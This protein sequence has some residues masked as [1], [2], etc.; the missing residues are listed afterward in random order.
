MDKGFFD[1]EIFW[2]QI[3]RDRMKEVKEE[4]FNFMFRGQYNSDSQ[5][6]DDIALGRYETFVDVDIVNV[7][8]D[9]LHIRAYKVDLHPFHESF[10]H[11]ILGSFTED[12]STVLDDLECS[13]SY[14]PSALVFNESQEYQEPENGFIQ[15]SI[16]WPDSAYYERDEAYE[17]IKRMFGKDIL[18]EI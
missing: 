6:I 18:S 4:S 1:R 12:I 8:L 14:E 9:A 10:S 3:T 7:D 11:K 2:D 15:G 5:S 17:D 16:Y 13:W